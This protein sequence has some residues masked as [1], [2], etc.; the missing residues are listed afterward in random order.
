M[1]FHAKKRR[2]KPNRQGNAEQVNKTTEKKT[3]IKAVHR[4]KKKS[5]MNKT[6]L[7]NTKAKKVQDTPKL[8]GAKN[9]R[10]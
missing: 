1:R 3:Q 7:K 10:Q 2:K 8:R 9:I 5:K 6:I 4:G